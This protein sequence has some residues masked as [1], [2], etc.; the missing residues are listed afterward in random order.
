MFADFA[1]WSNWAEWGVC[2]CQQ[3]ARTRSCNYDSPYLTKGCVGKSYETKPC[4]GGVPCPGSGRHYIEASTTQRP[5]P[6]YYT[7]APQPRGGREPPKVGY[8]LQLHPL[9]NA[10]LSRDGRMQSSDLIGTTKRPLPS[11]SDSSH[12]GNGDEQPRR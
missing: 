12:T 10:W 3:R 9:S 11:V 5:A 4:T 8:A 2:F 7:L 1:K 6:T